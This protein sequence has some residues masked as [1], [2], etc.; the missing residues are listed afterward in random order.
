MVSL[1]LSQNT[2]RWLVLLFR[3]LAGSLV[4]V[5]PRLRIARSDMRRFRYNLSHGYR[6]YGLSGGTIPLLCGFAPKKYNLLGQIP[7]MLGHFFTRWR[8]RGVVLFLFVAHGA[9]PV[10]D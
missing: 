9:P 3:Y 2:H 6:V 10:R 1:A 8:T 5:R 7:Y 4:R